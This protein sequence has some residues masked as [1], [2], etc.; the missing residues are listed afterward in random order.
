[1]WFGTVDGVSAKVQWVPL[2]AVG[3]QANRAGWSDE[4]GFENGGANIASST[5]HHRSYEMEFP[6]QENIDLDL[7]ADYS[8]GLYGTGRLYF[9][10]RMIM[11]Q[12]LLAPQWGAPMTCG[13]GGFPH[14]GT[15]VS[16]ATTAV[17]TFGQPKLTN[18][19]K[20]SKASY[21]IPTDPAQSSMV[22]PIPP[23][24]ALWWGWSGTRT[25][26]GVLTMAAH[27]ISDGVMVYF[28]QTP[29]AVT[30][31]SQMQA[32]SISGATYDWA[33]LFI[34]RT[35]AGT[36]IISGSSPTY[37]GTAITAGRQ[38]PAYTIANPSKVFYFGSFESPASIS[39]T[40]VTTP[41]GMTSVGGA[42]STPAVATIATVMN[43][44]QAQLAATTTAIGDYT[45]PAGATASRVA[46]Q[47]VAV[48]GTVSMMGYTSAAVQNN[49]SMITISVPGTVA[50]N[51]VLLACIRGSSTSADADWAA[52]G[53]E[54]VGPAFVPNSGAGALGMYVH[55]VT[56]AV[57][58]PRSYTFKHGG[59]GRAVGMMIDLRG[60]GFDVSTVSPTSAVAQLWPVGVTPALTGNFVPGKGNTG[61]RFSGGALP[62]NYVL[63]DDMGRNVHLVGMSATLVETGAWENA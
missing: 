32:P 61:C 38:I 6:V 45:V 12:N 57:N 37:T 58:E 22:I 35:V 56:D 60:V 3:M 2:P 34:N 62:Q 16:Q 42:V 24:H 10:D 63:R 11:D 40:P 27:R 4:V 43:V 31:S 9:V 17:N 41:A 15:Y 14:I 7:F 51:D 26:T 39:R 50:N 54:R 21:T 25:G 52:Q 18:T 48:R 13:L 29:L 46:A 44:Y 33:R 19:Y 1:M 59:Y 49:T 30:S 53:W 55:T 36:D 8:T 47:S 28:D 5:G 23:T 20:L